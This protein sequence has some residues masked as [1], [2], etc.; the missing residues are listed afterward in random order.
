MKKI[1]IKK[2]ELSDL[3]KIQE[4]SRKTIDKS[5]RSFMWDEWVDWYINSWEADKEIEKYIN[6]MDILLEDNNII[7]FSITFNDFIH[8][9]MVDFDLH[10]KW[11][12]SKLLKISENKLF[13]K[14]C[15]IIKLETFEG[16]KQAINFYLKNNWKIVKKEKDENFDFVRVF[17][18]KSI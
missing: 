2:A 1:I 3:F 9:M 16:N 4:I 7:A 11:Y 14:W 10:R 13:E 15:K 5:F 8:L 17:F 6:S 12:G 18:E